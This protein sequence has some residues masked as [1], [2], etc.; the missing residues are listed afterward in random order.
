MRDQKMFQIRLLSE[1]FTKVY[2]QLQNNLKG[3]LHDAISEWAEQVVY[4][5]K[6]LAPY[7]TGFLSDSLDVFDYGSRTTIFSNCPYAQYVIG[8]HGSYPPNPFLWDAVA[9]AMPQLEVEIMFRL[10]ELLQV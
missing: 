1:D 5:A 4:N 8:G 7:R 9:D 10:T 6:A 2:S 3:E